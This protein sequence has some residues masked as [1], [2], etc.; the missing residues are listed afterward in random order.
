MT[1]LHKFFNACFE[2]GRVPETWSKGSINPIPKA[3]TSASRGSFS[4]RGITLAP[5]TFKVYCTILN[6]RLKSWNEQHNLIVD[7]QNGF[8]KQRSTLD[9]LTT[10]TSIIENRKKQGNQH[11]VPL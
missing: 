1:F 7:E 10:L 3:S 5:V 2:T 8:R 9:H 6:E 4:Y 11:S